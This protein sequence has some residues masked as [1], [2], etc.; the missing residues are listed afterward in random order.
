LRH[1]LASRWWQHPGHQVLGAV[2]TVLFLSGSVIVLVYKIFGLKSGLADGLI[3][4]SCVSNLQNQPDLWLDECPYLY[5]HPSSREID[6][7]RVELVSTQDDPGQLLSLNRS[8]F[9][10]AQFAQVSG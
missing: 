10:G 7:L 2:P 9:D 5:A 4:N 1:I 8:A 6:A 3:F